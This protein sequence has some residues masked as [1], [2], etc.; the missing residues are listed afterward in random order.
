[1]TSTYYP[2]LGKEGHYAPLSDAY[3]KST[4]KEHQPSLQA[5]KGRQKTLPLP[6][7]VQ[8]VKNV[9]AIRARARARGVHSEMR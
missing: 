7:S 9:D 6:G 2:I 5:S 1:M 8:H 4:T 3:A